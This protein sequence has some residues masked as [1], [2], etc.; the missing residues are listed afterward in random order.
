MIE[1][2]RLVLSLGRFGDELV[3][4]LVIKRETLLDDA[5][6]LV[7]LA[8]LHFSIDRRGVDQQCGCR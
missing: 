8:L 1:I 3:S 7:A 4:R 6:K 2:D 5:V